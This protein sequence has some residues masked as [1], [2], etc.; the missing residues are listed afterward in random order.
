MK[1]LIFCLALIGIFG[2]SYSQKLQPGAVQVAYSTFAAVTDTAT[3]TGDVWM[4]LGY[5][6]SGYIAFEKDGYL[7]IQPILA[8]LTGTTAGNVFLQGSVDGTNFVTLNSGNSDLV[9]ANDTLTAVD[10]ASTLW[11]IRIKYPIYRVF[12]DGSGT[13]TSTI[14]ATYFYLKPEN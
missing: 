13:H 5:T 12:Y 1:K 6:S 9:A 11:T 3:N 10:G 14:A 4:G 7:S 8:N 2:F